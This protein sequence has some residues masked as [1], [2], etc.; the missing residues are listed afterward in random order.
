MHVG[1]RS[2][3]Q[4]HRAGSGL[5]AGS[6]DMGGDRAVALGHSVVDGQRLEPALQPREPSEPDGAYVGG[7]RHEDS[8]VELSDA[9]RADRELPR[10]R[11]YA[12]G[13]EEDNRGRWPWDVGVRGFQPVFGPRNRLLD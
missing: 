8:E 13:D 7:A 9:D 5:S 10:D 6:H 12:F 1:C 11:L 3:E 4:I 2:E